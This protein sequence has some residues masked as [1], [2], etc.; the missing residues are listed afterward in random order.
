MKT[1][2]IHGL[3]S[4]PVPEKTQIMK[5]AGLTVVALHINYREQLAVYETLKDTSIR[6]KVKFI[7]GS[8]LGG[9]LAYWLAEDLGLPCLLFNP[10]MTY[11]DVFYSKIP[12]RSCNTSVKPKNPTLWLCTKRTEGRIPR[13]K[14]WR[15]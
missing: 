9:Y 5:D 4:Y 6:K 15:E 11:D 2:Y 8:S 1:L 13:R 12:A 14:A 7:I 10:A 3:D